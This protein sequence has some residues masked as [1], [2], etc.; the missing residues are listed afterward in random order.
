MIYLCDSYDQNHG[1]WLTQVDDPSNRRNVS[2][3]AIGRTFHEAYDR[4][5]HWDVS[6]WNIC[7]LKSTNTIVEN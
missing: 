5:D 7:I 6:K 2:E 3:R 4:G 1:F